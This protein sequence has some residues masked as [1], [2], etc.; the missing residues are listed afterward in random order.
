VTGTA[1]KEFPHALQ[2]AVRKPHVLYNILS[3]LFQSLVPAHAVRG[4]RDFFLHCNLLPVLGN[5]QNINIR[6]KLF[7]FNKKKGVVK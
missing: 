6:N 2:K 7:T 5:E 3:K 4:E 1:S